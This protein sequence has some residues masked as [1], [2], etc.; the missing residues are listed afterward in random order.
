MTIIYHEEDGDPN[1]LT[2]RN[3]G[4]IGYG[5]LGRPMALNLH[6]SGLQVVVGVRGH[7]IQTDAIRPASML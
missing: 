1:Y 3:V 5:N 4:V 7:P 6:D 2:G